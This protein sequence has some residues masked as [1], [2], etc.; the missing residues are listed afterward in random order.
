MIGRFL[1][2]PVLSIAIFC[3]VPSWAIAA[4]ASEGPAAAPPSLQDDLRELVESPGVPGYEDQVAARI[5]SKL[6][7]LHPVTDNMWNVV[8]TLGSGEPRRL[9]VTPTDEP[10]F[11]VSNI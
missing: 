9:I 11:V 10:G 7:G 5:R 8:I 4:V 2:K 6:V 1:G 3:I